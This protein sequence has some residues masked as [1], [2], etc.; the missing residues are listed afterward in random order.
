VV[1]TFVPGQELAAMCDESGCPS[2]TDYS[3][4]PT[5]ANVRHP[6]ASATVTAKSAGASSSSVTA[7]RSRGKRSVKGA[8]A[9]GLARMLI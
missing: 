4:Q 3:S 7:G 1:E 9:L 6:E 5:V 8:A 2:A